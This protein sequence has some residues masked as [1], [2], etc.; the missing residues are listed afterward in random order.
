MK[1]TPR[2]VAAFCGLL[3]LMIV[4][5]SG[6]LGTAW[7]PPDASWAVLYLAGFHFRREW[8]W[9]LPTLLFTAVAVD[10]ILIR[11]LGV[12][13]YCVT[14]AYVFMLPAYS[15]LW[16]GGAWMRR[17]Y[18]HDAADLIRCAAS[19]GIAASLCFLLTNASFYWLGGRIPNP[20]LGGWG[21]NFMQWY[22]GFVGVPFVYTGIAALLQA[23][24][25]KPVRARVEADVH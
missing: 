4:T 23:V 6:H 20:G 8:R 7:Q 14:M 21:R 13:A 19:L 22:P 2:P 9:A 24:M 10:F 12:S 16:L 25:A 1:L 15:L 11:D 3:A 18:R 5:R 17:A